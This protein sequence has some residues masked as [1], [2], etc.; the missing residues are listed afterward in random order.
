[1]LKV[2]K[3]DILNRQI[4]FIQKW[5]DLIVWMSKSIFNILRII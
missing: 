3:D 1:M 2:F 5:S 4:S